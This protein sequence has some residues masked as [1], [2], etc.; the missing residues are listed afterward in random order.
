MS[1]RDIVSINDFF[2]VRINSKFFLLIEIQ[3]DIST[4][5]KDEIIFIPLSSHEAN[6]LME[7]GV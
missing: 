3:M 4:T 7:M 1:T 5:K 2:I 6:A